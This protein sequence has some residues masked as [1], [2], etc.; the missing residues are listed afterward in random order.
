VEGMPAKSYSGYEIKER[1]TEKMN[2]DVTM[3]K[4]VRLFRWELK[5]KFKYIYEK[6]Y[7]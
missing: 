6:K 1:K 4:I 3:K 5:E 7:F 2:V